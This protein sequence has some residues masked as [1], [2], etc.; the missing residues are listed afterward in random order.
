VT[1]DLR[2]RVAL[3][4]GAGRGIGEATAREFAR[5]G[6]RVVVNDNG[7]S[8]DGYPEDETVADR[9]AGDILDSGGEAVVSRH[10]I[11][12]VDGAEAAFALALDR[13]QQL[14]ILVNNAGTL[15]IKPIWEV[16]P[17]DW[18]SVL[19]SHLTHCYLLTRLACQWWR[20]ESVAGRPVDGRIVNL[21]AATG[22]VGR[23]DM[24]SN[25]A[26]AKGAMAA[27]TLVVAQEMREYGVTVNAVSPAAVRTRM[28]TH[29]SASLPEAVDGVDLHSA[30][31]VAPLVA[32]LASPEAGWLT[33]QVFRVVGGKIGLYQPWHVS[34]TMDS[35]QLWRT[36][37]LGHQL[38][39]LCGDQPEQ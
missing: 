29:V 15:R 10:D 28:A 26:A 37:E 11:G 6:A 33:G 35:R 18:H 19:D 34:A 1:V 27:L 31:N 24:G 32:Y 30:A 21:I 4:T 13:W 25:H 23:A 16:R 7:V 38:R 12:T 22:L 17:D 9:V 14:D 3:V 36:D 2:G 39:E 8:V 20:S 5:L